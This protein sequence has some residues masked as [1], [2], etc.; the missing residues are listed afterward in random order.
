[1]SDPINLTPGATA[2]GWVTWYIDGDP[3]VP[4]EVQITLGPTENTQRVT[5]RVVAGPAP[6]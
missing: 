6:E 1:M 4:P 5:A 3:G 2:E